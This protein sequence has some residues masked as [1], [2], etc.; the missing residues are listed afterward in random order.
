MRDQESKSWYANSG[1]NRRYKAAG[2]FCNP[3]LMLRQPPRF[4]SIVQLEYV[5]SYSQWSKKNRPARRGV[6][7][8]ALLREYI[9]YNGKAKGVGGGF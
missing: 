9:E 5:I 6:P 8:S 4:S 7:F 1:L 2:G 3:G